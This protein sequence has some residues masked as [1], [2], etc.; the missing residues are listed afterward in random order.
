MTATR[1][2]RRLGR[3]S[4]GF[5]VGSAVSIFVV[6]L[7]CLGLYG[8][9]Q[10]L[11]YQQRLE[12]EAAL[13]K[14]EFEKQVAVQS[15]RAKMDAADLLAQA[16]VKRAQGVAQANKIIAESLGGPEGY[17]RWKYIEMLEETANAP[18]RST[19]YIPTE[20]TMPI[21]EAGKRP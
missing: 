15:A 3:G 10:Y 14:A 1:T 4:F 21:L 11:V 9:P 16:D 19:I 17:L 2:D 8:C 18:G 12:G 20:A 5:G 7:L 6:I 13:A